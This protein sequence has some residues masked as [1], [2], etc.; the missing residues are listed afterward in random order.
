MRLDSLIL[1]G[2]WIDYYTVN[3]RRLA[4]HPFVSRVK[5]EPGVMTYILEKPY[6]LRAV[7]W[8]LLALL[9]LALAVLRRVILIY[10]R[11]RGWIKVPPQATPLRATTDTGSGAP[12][13]PASPVPPRS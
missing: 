2:E 13:P 8:T 5:L 1:Q 11:W 10:L 6:L 12:D 7:L 3:L 4:V 9:V